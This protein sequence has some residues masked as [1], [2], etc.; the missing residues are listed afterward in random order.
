M[1]KASVPM[2]NLYTVVRPFTAKAAI[3]GR[4]RQFQPGETFLCDPTG[5]DARIVIEADEFLFFVDR[6]TFNTCATF[7]GGFAA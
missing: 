4:K 1:Q 5:D 6:S 3:S 7:K 2:K